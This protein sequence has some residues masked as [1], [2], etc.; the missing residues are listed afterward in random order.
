MAIKS[1]PGTYVKINRT[2]KN[3]DKI[4]LKL[5]LR[6]RIIP[7]PSGAPDLAIMRGPIVLTLDNRFVE[8]QDTSV[9]LLTSRDSATKLDTS[10]KS[11]PSMETNPSVYEGYVKIKP[12]LLPKETQEY[13]T[14]KTIKSKPN[15][16][17]MAFE[18][19]F[20]VRP[21][22]FFNHHVKKLIMCDYSSAGDLWS[23]KNSY[24]VWMP[25]P[26]YPPPIWRLTSPEA[27]TRPVIPSALT[28]K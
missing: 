13:V 5:D 10:I 16:I 9:W 18:V 3:G 12:C 27:K 11:S 22:H 4:I 17:W 6:G 1:D 23:D 19:P 21:S 28:D 7:A 15:N 2:W 14:L 8:P 24:R 26:M 25:Q 20:L